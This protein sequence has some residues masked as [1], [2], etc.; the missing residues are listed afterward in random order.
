MTTG[1]DKLAYSIAELAEA[2]GVGRSFIYEE[3]KVGRLQLKKAGRRSLV[4][5]ADAESWLGALPKRDA[6]RSSDRIS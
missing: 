6:A 3:V 1:S 2:A 4:L 5:R